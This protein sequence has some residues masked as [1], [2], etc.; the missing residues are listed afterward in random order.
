MLHRGRGRRGASLLP[1]STSSSSQRKAALGRF[2]WCALPVRLSLLPH[3]S[4]SA[5]RQH[6]SHLHCALL[7]RAGSST[8]LEHGHAS[9][10]LQPSGTQNHDDYFID[11]NNATSM[12]MLLI[13]TE[14]CDIWFYMF[15][16]IAGIW[17]QENKGSRITNLNKLV[18]LPCYIWMEQNILVLLW[19]IQNALLLLC[20]IQD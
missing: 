17:R 18:N 19:C 4:F 9:S 5:P 15:W 11:M 6:A 14:F 12:K 20:R 2:S 16:I 10:P 7:M 8:C 13:K 3:G 1:T